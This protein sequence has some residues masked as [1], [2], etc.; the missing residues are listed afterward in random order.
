MNT[1]DVILRNFD[2]VLTTNVYTAVHLS[3]KWRIDVPAEDKWVGN[4]Q[5]LV[6][7]GVT[8]ESQYFAMRIPV[9]A[10]MKNSTAW[11]NEQNLIA[12]TLRELFLSQR[13]LRESL[14]NEA[15]CSDCGVQRASS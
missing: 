14:L 3:I 7:F 1:Q 11:I 2:A 10:S 13:S 12:G 6:W 4:Y 9:I 15:A 5:I 8:P